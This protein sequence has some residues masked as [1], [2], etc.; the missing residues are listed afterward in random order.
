MTIWDYGV[1]F[2]YGYSAAY[3]SEFH[4]GEDWTVT[5]RRKDIPVTV[6]GVTIGISGTTGNSTG[7]HTHV[8]RFVGG[9]HTNPN[10]GGQSLGDDA[11]VTQVDLVGNTKAGKFVR[12]RSQ[13]VDWLYMHLDSIS[14]KVGDKLKG[15]NNMPYIEQSVLDGLEA[16]KRTGQTLSFDPA[17]VAM[18]GTPGNPLTGDTSGITTVMNDFRVNKDAKIL[19]E[20]E[21]D[22]VLYPYVNAVSAAL[23]IPADPTKLTTVTTAITDLQND[24]EYEEVTEKLYRKKD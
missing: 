7:I 14:V 13:G 11:T 6:N 19:V 17:Y 9:S 10:G 4:T 15:G 12:V 16:W 20:K 1:K 2:P 18:G 3:G 22:E 24:S 8:G 21:R 23:N 5:D